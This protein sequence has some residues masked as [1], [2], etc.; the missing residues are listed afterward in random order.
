M[1][2]SPGATIGILGS[3]Q[4]GRML[5][6]AALK[7]GLRTHIYASEVEGPAYDAAAGR[8]IAPFDDEEALE[9]FAREVDIVTYELENVPTATVE[10]LNRHVPVRPGARA[11]ALT[12][13]RLIEKHSYATRVSGPRRSP[14]S[15][16]PARSSARSPSSAARR[17]SRPG[18]SATTAR[19]SR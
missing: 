9:K 19:A 1:I 13:D 6:I 3:G 18:A 8:T 12:Q 5:A 16:T 10:F 11:L 17:F 4:L 14:P 15:T 7:V 2:L